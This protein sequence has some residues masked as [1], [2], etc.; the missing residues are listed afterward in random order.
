MVTDR[1]KKVFGDGFDGDR[2]GRVLCRGVAWY[3]FG[4]NIAQAAT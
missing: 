2:D 3:E 1:K 4:R